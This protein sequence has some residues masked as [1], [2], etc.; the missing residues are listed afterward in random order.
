MY[1]DKTYNV[2]EEIKGINPDFNFRK[3]FS[4]APVTKQVKFVL[5]YYARLPFTWALQEDD[6]HSQI[7]PIA[8]TFTFV[9]VQR[10]FV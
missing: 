4:F 7:H 6:S 2:S 10:L 9:L 1:L 8:T 3:M 5:Y